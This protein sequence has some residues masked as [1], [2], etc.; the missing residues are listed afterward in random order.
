MGYIFN[1]LVRDSFLSRLTLLSNYF[2]FMSQLDSTE[3]HH[4][5]FIC[6]ANR[7][8]MGNCELACQNHTLYASFKTQAVSTIQSQ[9]EKCSPIKDEKY[10]K[11]YSN[12]YL[13]SFFKLC[14]F[15][16]SYI[17]QT[18][19]HTPPLT[20]LARELEEG[21]W[22]GRIESLQGGGKDEAFQLLTW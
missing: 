12:Y 17:Q 7:C 5:T 20:T 3:S 22:R 18:Q 8:I 11:K 6:E 15:Q 1:I 4:I 21:V 9:R 13:S 19:V 16:M 2:I 10:N 14:V